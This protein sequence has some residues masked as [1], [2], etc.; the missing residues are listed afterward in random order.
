MKTKR[1]HRCNKNRKTVKV[2]GRKKIASEYNGID[3]IVSGS[4]WKQ[5]HGGMM[6]LGSYG[7]KKRDYKLFKKSEESHYVL[8]YFHGK[9]EQGNI[10][11][12][13]VGVFSDDGKTYKYPLK[14]DDLNKAKKAYKDELMDNMGELAKNKKSESEI[15]DEIAERLSNQGKG[16]IIKDIND[17]EYPIFFETEEAYNKF[18]MS[19]TDPLAAA[20]ARPEN[21]MSME[22]ALKHVDDYKQDNEQQ[23]RAGP[24]S[25][26]GRK[27]ILKTRKRKHKRKTRRRKNN[28]RKS[29]RRS[30]KRR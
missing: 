17:T 19:I 29:R 26:G 28:K 2:G 23:L 24:G 8:I 13:V 25:S 14:D 1:S 27:N 15:P 30:I 7:W 21:I 6:R 20:T 4:F 3:P 11:F 22:E 10:K 5:G 18:K 12:N 9:T 16:L